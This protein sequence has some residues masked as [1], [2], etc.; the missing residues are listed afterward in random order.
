MGRKRIG[1]IGQGSRKRLGEMGI[2]VGLM[3][4]FR[5]ADGGYK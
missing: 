3:V 2:Q 5:E 4:V 1:G